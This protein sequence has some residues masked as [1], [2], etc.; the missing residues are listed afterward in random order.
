MKFTFVSIIRG[1]FKMPNNII[2]DCNF[3]LI[4]ILE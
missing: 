1:G 2:V 3:N 4:V